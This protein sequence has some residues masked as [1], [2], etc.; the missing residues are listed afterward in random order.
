MSED[1]SSEDEITKRI[2][3]DSVDTDLLTD[4]LY[5]NGSTSGK[6][7]CDR[8]KNTNLVQT[9]QSLRYIIEDD[10]HNHNFIKVTPEFQDFVAKN[11][12]KHLESQI[13][14]KTIKKK[15]KKDINE[16]YP[17]GI[18][19]FNRSTKLLD[20]FMDEPLIT[21]KRKRCDKS[22]SDKLIM[23]RASEMAVSP[24]WILNKDAVEGW[25]KVTKGKIIKVKPNDEGTYDVVSHE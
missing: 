6:K 5:K 1:S 7:P 4:D 17:K 25:T 14:E 16:V 11:L 3:R 24:E 13:I 15:H 21:V 18:H 8:I 2:L 23:Q 22:T 9:K 10:G 19:L 20:S 12:F